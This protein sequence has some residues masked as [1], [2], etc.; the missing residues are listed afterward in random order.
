M[1]NI[2]MVEAYLE[3]LLERGFG[4]RIEPDHQGDY[5]L[6]G[7]GEFFARVAADGPQRIPRVQVFAVAV[8]DV[9]S[10][11]ELL[12][13][14]NHINSQIAYARVFWVQAQVLIESDLV[15]ES[16]DHPGLDAAINTVGGLAAHLGSS[17]AEDFGGNSAF[18]QIEPEEVPTEGPG[19]Y[20]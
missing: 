12:K 7:K 16:L 5:P 17:L 8:R 9:E 3:K 1:P 18:V 6:P 20:L 2:E 13:A 19:M 11:P 10:T 4:Q 14:L 15:A